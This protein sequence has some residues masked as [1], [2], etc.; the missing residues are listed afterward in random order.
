MFFFLVESSQ[1]CIFIL[2]RPSQAFPVDAVS[3]GAILRVSAA[4]VCS[5]IFV[6]ADSRENGQFSIAMLNNQRVV[7]G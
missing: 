4:I 6:D 7:A 5:V 2:K 3:C 1:A